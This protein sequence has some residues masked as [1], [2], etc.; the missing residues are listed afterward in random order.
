MACAGIGAQASGVPRDTYS[1]TAKVKGYTLS[2]STATISVGQNTI[3]L[4]QF[5]PAAVASSASLLVDSGL[6][7]LGLVVGAVV[8]YAVIKHE[9]SRKKGKGNQ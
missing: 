7:I 6:L 5:K 2:S 9:A 4:L 8:A 1:F 3:V